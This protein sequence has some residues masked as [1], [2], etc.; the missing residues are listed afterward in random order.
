MRVLRGSEISESL[1]SKCESSRLNRSRSRGRSLAH[2]LLRPPPNI[3]AHWY[4]YTWRQ[5]RLRAADSCTSFT[6]CSS[7]K[8]RHAWPRAAQA[9]HAPHV[10]SQRCPVHL[11][12]KGFCAAGVMTGGSGNSKDKP[13]PGEISYCPPDIFSSSSNNNNS[14]KLESKSDSRSATAKNQQPKTSSA[15]A[16]AADE[17]SQ[18]KVDPQPAQP[19]RPTLVKSFHLVRHVWWYPCVIVSTTSRSA[20]CACLEGYRYVVSIDWLHVVYVHTLAWQSRHRARPVLRS[21]QH[22]LLCSNTH[23]AHTSVVLL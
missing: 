2:S 15:I 18:Q 6:V 1:K 23:R 17:A 11:R 13:D 20:L 8:R 9:R 12:A 3:S 7:A 10:T 16:A 14:S 4:M 19:Q 21:W 5:S 22:R